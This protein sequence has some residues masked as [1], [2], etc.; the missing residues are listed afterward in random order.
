MFAIIKLKHSIIVFFLTLILIVVSTAAA[1]NV[2]PA[3]AN[4]QPVQPLRLPIIMY[5]GLVSDVSYQ[6]Q[7]MIDPN[8]FEQD[9]IYL[10]DNGY[11][12][13][14][15]S[16]LEDYVENRKPLPEKPIIL[17]FDD[18]YYNN[19]V[20]AYPL[21]KKYQQKAVISP[22]GI[23]ADRA[24]EEQ[25]KNPL[26]SQCGWTE[27]KEMS[28]SGLVEIQN[29]TYNLHQNDTDRKGAA[30]RPNESEAEYEEMLLNDLQM[31]SDKM[32]QNLQQR[33][34]AF[35]YPFGAKSKSTL[36][37]VK[38]AGYR[39][40]LDCEQKMNLIN[41]IEDLYTLHRFLRPGQVS[42]K[43]FFEN[44]VKIGTA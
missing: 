22:I 11:H 27:L 38:K 5:H 16:E 10:K 25:R 26:Y 36:S 12:T 21:L 13:I 39:A 6:N 4:F 9:L 17:T 43:V 44:T 2:I 28:C 23:T 18:G 37:I 15:I 20:Y 1:V 31:F 3:V 14:F 24:E 19:Y 33:P 41:D 8:L 35:V 29:H 7:Y 34:N 32:Y 40:V 42:S 30:A